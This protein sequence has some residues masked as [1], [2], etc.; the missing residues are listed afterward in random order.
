MIGRD[1]LGVVLAAGLSSRM[2]P[3]A[4]K[5]TQIL[6]G[7]PMVW[8]PVTNWSRSKPGTR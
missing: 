6:G 4:N 7:H 5:L 3:E 1:T 8:Y 2:G